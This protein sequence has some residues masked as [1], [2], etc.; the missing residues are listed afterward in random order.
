M[1][2]RA[3]E[4]LLPR[5]RPQAEWV[6]VVDTAVW[7]EPEGNCWPPD[8]QATMGSRYVVH[9]YALAVFAERNA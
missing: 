3:I 8:R 7:A 2:H 6:R 9:P 1:D 5:P 4:F